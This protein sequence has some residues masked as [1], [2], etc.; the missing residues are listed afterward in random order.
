LTEPCAL[1]VG[2]LERAAAVAD[3]LRL[4]FVELP[5]V[6]RAAVSAWLFEPPAPIAF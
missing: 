5:P 4:W 1:H 2:A 3:L 6:T